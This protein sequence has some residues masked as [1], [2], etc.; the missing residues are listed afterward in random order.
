MPEN[1]DDR[2]KTLLEWFGLKTVAEMAKPRWVGAGVTFVLMLLFLVALV[3]A[4]MVLVHTIGQ[5]AN[6]DAAGPN[7]GAGALVAALLGA[8][9]LIWATVI[10]QTTLNFQKEG[11]ITDRISKAVEQL[12][13]EKTVERIGRPVTVWTGKLEQINYDANHAEKFADKPRTRLSRKEWKQTWNDERTVIQWQGET[14]DKTKG[15]LVGAEGNWQVFKETAPNIEVRIGGILSLERIAQDSTRYDNG[16]D[17]V[18]VMEILCAYVRENAPA[19]GAKTGPT[20]ELKGQNDLNTK[21]AASS[22]VHKWLSQLTKPRLDV[23]IALKVIGRRSKLQR[24]VEDEYA[25]LTGHAYQIDLSHTNLQRADLESSNFERTSFFRSHLEG[26]YGNYTRF[27]SCNFV[28]ADLTGMAASQSDFSFAKFGSADFSF[29]FLDR[30]LFNQS[31]FSHTHF[32]DTQLFSTVFDF[33][34]PKKQESIPVNSVFFV[35][36]KMQGAILKGY[37]SSGIIIGFPLAGEEGAETYL[38]GLGFRNA[39]LIPRILFSDEGHEALVFPKTF[40]ENS[41]GDLSVNIGDTASPTHWPKLTL[42]DIRYKEEIT[43][44]RANP[45]S[46]TP[47]LS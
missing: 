18:R 40:L 14:I 33:E 35:R 38:P 27:C 45:I 13:A 43:K 10:K 44:W 23:A 31:Q 30:S 9:F 17:H 8:P 36:S 42:D 1:N 3:A 12:G 6:P 25:H 29:A 41:F 46:Y 7:L 11:H 32:V 22:E 19:R 5:V 47:P 39:N 21:L 15:E 20:A 28:Y 26:A 4:V 34:Y 24:L 16:R 2:P 37:L